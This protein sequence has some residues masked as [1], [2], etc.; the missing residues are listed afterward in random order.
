MTGGYLPPWVLQVVGLAVFLFFV[1]FWAVTGRVEPTLLA[2][3]GG[4][5]GAGLYADARRALTT[6]NQPTPPPP[7]ATDA[8]PNGQNA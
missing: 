5:I 3:A 7:A 6:S 1:A 2:A 8:R 4:L